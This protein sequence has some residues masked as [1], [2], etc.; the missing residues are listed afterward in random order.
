MIQ[1]SMILKEEAEVFLIILY[2]NSYK[3]NESKIK[4]LSFILCLVR[5][6]MQMCKWLLQPAEQNAAL[7]KFRRHLVSKLHTAVIKGWER[8]GI[9]RGTAAQSVVAWLREQQ[10]CH[11][12]V[13]SVHSRTQRLS[14]RW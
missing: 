5:S 6:E 10:K 4:I 12:C 3:A 11:V 2:I 13:K 1:F 7:M 8:F 14:I 9:R